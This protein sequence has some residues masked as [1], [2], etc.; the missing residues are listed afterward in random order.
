[1]KIIVRRIDN[2]FLI[3]D[4]SE[5]DENGDTRPVITCVE[6]GEDT[7]ESETLAAPRAMQRLLW[8]LVDALGEFGSRYDKE[9]I[10]IN[11]EHGD[12]YNCEDKNCEICKNSPCHCWG[13]S[14][15]EE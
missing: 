7:E 3:T 15:A 4:L 10:R 14:C 2:G 11:I 5:Q 1:M 6:I 12:K 13:K 9:R 8:H